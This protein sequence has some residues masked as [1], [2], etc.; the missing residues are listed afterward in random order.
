[1]LINISKKNKKSVARLKKI[2]YNI[3]NQKKEIEQKIIQFKEE[4]LLFKDK[5]YGE[6]VNEI[7]KKMKNLTKKMTTI[8]NNYLYWKYCNGGR[9]IKKIRVK[10][11]N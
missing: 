6:C 9:L 4:I 2:E 10:I 8:E 11:M 3:N 5:C 7:N 1:M